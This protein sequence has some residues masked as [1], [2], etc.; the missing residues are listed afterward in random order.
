MTFTNFILKIFQNL[1]TIILYLFSNQLNEAKLLKNF[2][3]QKKIIFFDIGSNLGNYTKFIEKCFKY[4]LLQVYSFEPNYKSYQIQKK[5]F[6]KSSIRLNN[7]AINNTNTDKFF[8]ERFISSQSSLIANEKA[9]SS[10]NFL[11]KI[12]KKTIIPTIT[13]NKYCKLNRINQIDFLKIDTEGNDFNVLLSANKLLLNKKI[14]LIKIE[15]I[16]KKNFNKIYNYLYSCGYEILGFTNQKYMD[17]KL[18]FCDVFFSLR[19][20]F[21]KS[22]HTSL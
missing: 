1:N 5:L 12:S 14:K 16:I 4:K 8:Y 3:L 22:F 18:I 21:S 9:L 11:C 13:L 17:D 15:V 6:S 10:N 7:I 20:K 19:N 2:F